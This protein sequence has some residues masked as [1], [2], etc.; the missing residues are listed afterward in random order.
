M[1]RAVKTI[2]RLPLL[3]IALVIALCGAP[4]LAATR[5][6]SPHHPGAIDQGDGP[7]VRP[8]KTLSFAMRQLMPGDTLKI[9]AGTYRDAM[10]FPKRAWSRAQPTTIEG[11]AEGAV[12]VLGSEIVEGW[13]AKGGGVYVKRPWIVEPQQVLFEG[14]A[15]RQ[16]GGTI[17]KGYPTSPTHELT[18]LHQSQGGIWP[19]RQ[20]GSRDDLPANSFFYDHAEKELVIRLKNEIAAEKLAIEISLRPYLVQGQD[21]SGITIRNI[22]FRYSNTTTTSR[23]GA[24]TLVGAGN[25]LEHL[26]IEDMDGVGI[27][28]SGDDNLVRN[29]KVT[30]SGYL[31]IKA[32]GR[33]VLIESNEVSFNNNRRF[34][35]WWEAGGMKFVGEGG[36]RASRVRNNKVY[37]NYGDGIWFDWGNDNN[38]IERN[39]AAYNEGFG[40]H[41]EASSRA[42]IQDNEVVGNTQRGIYVI[43]SRQSLI[44]HNLVAF[45]QLEGVAIVDEKRAD[46]KGILDLRP[47]SNIVFANVFGWNGE[48]AV[49]LPGHEYSGVSDA[50][51]FLNDKR[52]PMFSMGWPKGP[53]GKIS[54]DKW[55][56]E[57]KQDQDS[58]TVQLDIPDRVKAVIQRGGAPVD[59]SFI[60]V[61]R[62]KFRVIEMPSSVSL[63]QGVSLG[64]KAGPR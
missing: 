55:R 2:S 22:H 51:L 14:V 46:P 6:V 35:K 31:G 64:N 13:Q 41:Y 1:W 61:E 17:F 16:I 39:V 21:V 58:S 32:R 24:V 27:E 57:A 18:P 38:T 48:L 50:N 44:I 19:S 25:T 34:N 49:I 9:A 26:I 40:I 29:C 10:I 8:Y 45:N 56:L 15:L 4:V 43:H 7:A 60:D 3:L 23:Q 20:T 47:K 30:R 59:W 62:S 28:V 36:L 52:N 63:P 33:N 42:L 37:H 53:F 5:Y 54:W 12:T 11:D